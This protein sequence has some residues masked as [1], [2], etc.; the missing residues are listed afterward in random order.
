MMKYV[1]K[2]NGLLYRDR[3]LLKKIRGENREQNKLTL[4]S[5]PSG[6]C[7]TEKKYVKKRKT[8]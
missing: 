2:D 8:K 7:K 4:V 6:I 5:R 1:R 3:K